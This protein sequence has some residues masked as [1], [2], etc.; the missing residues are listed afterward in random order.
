M[1]YHRNSAPALAI[2]GT[3]AII[4]TSAW[5]MPLASL[6][7]PDT[8]VGVAQHVEAPA[9]SALCLPP[10]R[11]QKICISVPPPPG[12]PPLSVDTPGYAD[13]V[14][15]PNIDHLPFMFIATRQNPLV[16][17]KNFEG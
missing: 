4:S 5:A 6:R 10:R 13:E 12:K 8:L 9:V 2:I 14:T 7:S 3:A 15:R 16:T 11:L 17:S 1:Q